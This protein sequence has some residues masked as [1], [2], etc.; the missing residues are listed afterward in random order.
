MSEFT[1][2]CW[3]CYIAR[4]MTD[5]SHC[6]KHGTDEQKAENRRKAY[7]SIARLAERRI[8]RMVPK[9]GEP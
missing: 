7:E 1:Y 4:T 2:S 3:D 8:M 5:Q 9:K 6:P